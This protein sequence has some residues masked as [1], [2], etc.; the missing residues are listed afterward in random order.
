LLI[1]KIPY[2]SL[3]IKFILNDQIKIQVMFMEKHVHSGFGSGSFVDANKVI[4]ILL[5]RDEV[6]LDVGC[7]PGDYLLI[8]SKI[9]KNTIGIDTHKESIERVKKLGF[10][11]IFADTTKKIPLKNKS[12]DAVLMSNV[13]HGFVANETE[14]NAVSEISRVLKQN[15]K[16]GVV[17]F[18]KKQ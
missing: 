15:G 5:K 3:G 12:I 4:S 9:T 10:K 8:A 11:R 16:L 13:L 1:V 6:F 14:K 2:F 17:E 7:G 18:K